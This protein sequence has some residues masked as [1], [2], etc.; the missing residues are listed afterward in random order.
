MDVKLVLLRH[1]VL[2]HVLDLVHLKKISQASMGDYPETLLSFGF[3]CENYSSCSKVRGG[4]VAHKILVSSPV[5]FLPYWAFELG[6]TGLG[7]GLGGLGTKGMGLG[8]DN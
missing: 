1:I 5:P 4:V 6:L 2:L 3:S 7:K 8:L